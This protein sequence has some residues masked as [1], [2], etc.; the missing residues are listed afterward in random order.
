MNPRDQWKADLE[1]MRAEG[2]AFAKRA[3]YQRQLAIDL[4]KK[5]DWLGALKADMRAGEYRKS[6]DQFLAEAKK[7]KSQWGFR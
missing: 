5:R 3:T 1:R 4:R 2:A 6:R 7:I